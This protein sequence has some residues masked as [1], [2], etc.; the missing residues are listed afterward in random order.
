MLNIFTFIHKFQ[1][2][3]SYTLNTFGPQ[4]QEILYEAQKHL[5]KNIHAEGRS[6]IPSIPGQNT[7]LNI[8]FTRRPAVILLNYVE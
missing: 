3:N 1:N 2:M 8:T 5:G 7:Q 6:D 4:L